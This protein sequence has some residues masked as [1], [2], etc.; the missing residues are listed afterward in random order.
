MGPQKYDYQSDF[1][2]KYFGQGREEGIREGIRDGARD[3]VREVLLAQLTARFGEL[4][5][6]VRRRVEQAELDDLQRWAGR[7]INPDA[8]LTDVLDP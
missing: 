8:T 7:V 1:A 3:G 5:D 6:S 2:K 4:S